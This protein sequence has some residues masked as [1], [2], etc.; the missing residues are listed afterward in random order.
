MATLY[1]T[2]Y[3]GIGNQG[4][5]IQAPRGHLASQEVAVGA[6]SA[7]SATLNRST[8]L[9][10]LLSDVPC[11]VAFGSDP[12]AETDTRMALAA[13]VV[14]YVCVALN[15]DQKIAVIERAVP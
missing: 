10:R 9:V 15:S 1:I 12:D 6:T 8:M 3:L 5:H 14:E 11:F 13:E 2:E 7:S 4:D